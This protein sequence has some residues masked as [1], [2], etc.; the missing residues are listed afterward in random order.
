[1]PNFAAMNQ[2]FLQVDWPFVVFIFLCLAAII[3][4]FY[5]LFFFSRL[6]FFKIKKKESSQTHPVSI[7]ICARDEAENLANHL[8]GVLL[9]EYPTTH[10][11]IVVNDNSVDE[12]KYILEALQKTYKQ[13]HP[14]ELTQEAKMIPGKKFPLA[15]GVKSAKHE[16][17]LLT[18]ADCLPA[19]EHWISSMQSSYDDNTELVLGYGPYHKQ[20]SLLNKL[21][22]WETYFAALQYLSYALAG[23]PY[24][25][26]GRNLSYKKTLFY[27]HK[28]FSAHNNIPGGDDDLLVNIAATKENTKINIDPDAFTLSRPEKTWRQWIRQKK[29]HYTTAKYYKKKHRAL[30]GFHSF[31]LFVFYPSL[32]VT[33]IYHDVQ[34]AGIVFGIKW[35]IQLPL[36]FMTMK[37]LKEK[38]LFPFVILFDIWQFFY[39]LIFAS[40]LFTKP[41]NSWK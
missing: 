15:I 13:L 1:M 12:S 19:S 31:S 2:F 7:V 33:A 40:S 14:I 41:R 30:L 3:Q 38:D 35:I 9:Q 24:M 25:G 6:A 22:R 18:D 8:P 34:L 27:R 37:K 23:I 36:Y 21:I 26:V 4:I 10:E 16:I 11:V 32:I 39:F 17:I 20:K 29:R 5:H 28:G